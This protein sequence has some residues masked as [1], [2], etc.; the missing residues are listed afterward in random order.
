M[1]VDLEAEELVSTAGERETLETFVD[2]YRRVLAAKLDG[3]SEAEV[4][5]RQVPSLTTLIGLVKHCAAVE[6]GWF[7]QRLGQRPAA[8]ISGNSRGDDDSWEVAET[9]TIA[10]VRAEFA[11][12]CAVSREIAAGMELDDAVPHHRMGRVSLRWI[13]VHMLEELA[14][15]AGH[16]DIL[17]EQIDGATGD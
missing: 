16:A 11:Q 10:D 5:R 15:H 2:Y 12:A 17:R 9:E 7:Q 1:T 8:E 13:Y 6:R 14:R 3:L 4:R